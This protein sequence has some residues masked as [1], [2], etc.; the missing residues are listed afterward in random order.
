MTHQPMTSTAPATTGMTVLDL[1]QAGHFAEIHELFAPQL[2]AMMPAEAL[3]AVWADR[4][5]PVRLGHRYRPA[6]ER[7]RRAQR[8]AGEVPAHVRTR[9]ADHDRVGRGRRLA[10]RHPAGARRAE[11]AATVYGP[12]EVRRAGRDGRLRPLAVPGTLSVPHRGGRTP[13]WYCSAVRDRWTAR[14]ARRAS[15]TC[16]S[17]SAPRRSSSSR[18][19]TSIC[20]IIILTA[21][22]GWHL[23]RYY[24]CR[25]EVSGQGRFRTGCACSPGHASGSRCTE[26]RFVQ[27]NPVVCARRPMSASYES[28]VAPWR[29]ATAAIMQSTMP[30]GVTPARRQRQ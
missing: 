12:R 3:Q 30:R 13:L 16:R 1:A 19:Q 8:R 25:P 17:R 28:S 10:D 27:D 20:S 6:G 18:I 2:R 26:R 29:S 9:G 7:A 24:G 21:L 14:A 15:P 5:Q 4:N 23:I 22:R 11:G